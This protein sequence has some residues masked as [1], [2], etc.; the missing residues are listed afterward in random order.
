M[1]LLLKSFFKKEYIMFKRY[2][3]NSIG[4]LLSI[5]AMFLLI[6]L[7]YR[8]VAGGS[9]NYGDTLEGIIVGYVLWFF[10]I[11]TYTTISD[12]IS[13]ECGTG[14]LEQL[15]MAAFPFKAVL[16]AITVSTFLFNLIMTV[17]ILFFA[18]YVTGH[19]LTFDLLSLI[20]VIIFTLL[21]F[22]GLGLIVGGIT[23]V[24]KKAGT[25]LNILQF[26]LIGCI[27]APVSKVKAFALLPGSLGSNMINKIMVQGK[28]LSDF[29]IET[30]VILALI[31][32]AYVVIGSIVYKICEG[33]AME[34]GSLGHY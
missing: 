32:V 3:F 25:F 4:G 24:F 31:G 17:G 19:F 13:T 23:L 1:G 18:M 22:Y 15:Y 9:V 5:C 6:F 2:M 16:L 34:R 30:I 27:V 20:P 12:V 8:G 10:G 29:P 33:K 11:L 26:A 14:T 7:G 21:C 28:H